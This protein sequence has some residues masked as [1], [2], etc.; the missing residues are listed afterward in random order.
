MTPLQTLSASWL[1]PGGHVQPWYW[2]MLPPTAAEAR[3]AGSATY[4]TGKPCHRRHTSYRDVRTQN[5]AL[6]AA[7]RRRDSSPEA[8]ERQNRQMREW[9]ERNIDAQRERERSYHAKDREASRRKARQ[10]QI[11]NPKKVARAVAAR[12]RRNRLAT[13]PWADLEAIRAFYKATPPG[14][15]VDHITPLRGKNICGLHVLEN[16]QYLDAIENIRK[17]NRWDG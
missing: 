13:P 10:Y 2:Q 3:A 11:D 15:S 4:F 14:M 17:S 6:C 1:P 5:C 8:R 12:A 7:E 16:L 9:R